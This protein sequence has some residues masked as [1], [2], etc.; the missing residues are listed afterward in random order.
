MILGVRDRTKQDVGCELM[1]EE[2][3]DIEACLESCL[4]KRTTL[5]LMLCRSVTTC[6]YQ[7]EM[8]GLE[9]QVYGFP[10]LQSFR[11]SCHSWQTLMILGYGCCKLKVC[12][13]SQFLGWNII[14]NVLVFEAG[15]FGKCLG[16]DS[17]PSW[18][19]LVSLQKRPQRTSLSLLPC[20]DTTKR[21]LSRKQVLKTANL[22]ALWS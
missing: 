11:G 8:R 12:A 14:P 9:G 17:G 3:E 10:R 21:W 16:Q 18:M 13:L 7:K 15:I 1:F 22:L 4:S 2:V 6:W 5:L 20:E 19:G